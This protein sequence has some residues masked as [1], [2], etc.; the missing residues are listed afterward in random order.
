IL[1]I[2]RQLRLSE[3][4]CPD[5]GCFVVMP[6]RLLDSAWELALVKSRVP[7]SSSAVFE[8]LIKINA[9]LKSNKEWNN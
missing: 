8:Y 5:G 2:T 1:L 4:R 7:A 3:L 9:G 6:F